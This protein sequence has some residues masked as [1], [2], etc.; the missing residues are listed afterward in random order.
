MAA[1]TE[2]RQ[3]P[4][5]RNW[6]VIAPE[7]GRRPDVFRA[8]RG[9]L[10]GDAACPFCPG[11]EAE[12]PGELWRLDGPDGNWRVRVVPNKFAL[13]AG[14]GSARRHVSP[15]GFVAMPGVGWHEVVIES[16]DH[17]ADLARA[18]D[19]AVRNVLE[20]YRAR[21]RELRAGGSALVIVFRNHGPGAGT[22]LAHPHSQI[23][24]SPVVPV[25]IRQRFDV[26]M[27]HYDD[28]GTCLY[29]D[30]L[31]RELSDGRRV[32]LEGARFVAFQPFASASPFET[33]IM[34]RFH[35]PSFGDADDDAL[36]DL[37]SILRSVLSG[38]SREL[39]DPDYNYVIQSAPVG[40]E[41]REY[42]V[43]HLRI[44]PRL[45][46]AAGFELGSGMLVNPS[47]PE[48]TAAALRRAIDQ[49][50]GMRRGG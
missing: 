21:Y 22:S 17:G 14:D 38:L 45:S 23:V 42:F 47:R 7:R 4:S 8:Q 12:T 48:D 16:S 20:A 43:W 33:W 1:M 46:T 27:Q 35:Q 3:D 29:V 34:P 13:L 49:D 18:D 50:E 26:A 36:N 5:T 41:G 37:A 31:G 9:R 40:D 10:P 11:R 30:I 28:L 25:Q 39:G 32:V 19:A 15:E 2:L 44:V 6:V 24:A